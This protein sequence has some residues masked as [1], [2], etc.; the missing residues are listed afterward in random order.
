MITI[1]ADMARRIVE[2]LGTTPLPQDYADRFT[3]I[4]YLTAQVNK[5]TRP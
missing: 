4:A 3:L 1:P 5:E 2:L